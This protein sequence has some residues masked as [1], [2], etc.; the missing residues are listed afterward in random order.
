MAKE[1]VAGLMQGNPRIP[2]ILKELQGLSI[3]VLAG[4]TADTKIDLAAIRQEDTVVAALLNDAGSFSDITANHS[5]VD[6]HASGT[7]T[8]AA[9]RAA[10]GTA[11][12][13]GRVFTFKAAP[14][15][16]Q[17][18]ALGADNV[19]TAVNLAAAINAQ[20]GNKVKATADA[21]VVTV[22]ANADGTA[23]NAITLVGSAKVT[24]SG[25]TLA[26][27]TATGGVKF[28]SS[29]ATKQVILFWFNKR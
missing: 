7:L 3:S 20:E 27:G 29:T 19:A 22:T 9:D 18:V 6:T 4:A 1:S 5:I 11:A 23:G 10:N 13:A 21:G 15:G 17:E 28:S 2:K 26:G 12:V 8:I 14:A 24:A 16:V 25:A